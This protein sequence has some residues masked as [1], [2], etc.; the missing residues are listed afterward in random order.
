MK[1]KPKTVEQVEG[2]LNCNIIVL[3]LASKLIVKCTLHKLYVMFI[4]LF[5]N[6]PIHNFVG[7]T[8]ALIN[9]VFVEITCV[10]YFLSGS[11]QYLYP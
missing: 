2:P 8:V 7:L 3:S 10:S 5:Q 9:L 1:I 11:V 4:R 6:F